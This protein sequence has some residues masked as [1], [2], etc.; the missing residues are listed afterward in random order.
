MQFMIKFIVDHK[1]NTTIQ[2]MYL[3]Q[4]ITPFVGGRYTKINGFDYVIN[5]KKAAGIQR[6]LAN[7]N[8]VE[9]DINSLITEAN[10]FMYMYCRTD[11]L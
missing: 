5:N 9:N 3:Q 10:R 11:V 4:M 2:K 1:T 8:C 6:M 7:I